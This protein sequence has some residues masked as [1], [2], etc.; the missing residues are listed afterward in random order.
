M[1]CIPMALKDH[2]THRPAKEHHAET[3]S[4]IEAALDGS[5][6]KK[7]IAPSIRLRRHPGKG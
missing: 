3:I 4:V 5:P 2:E 6:L 7:A 1:A